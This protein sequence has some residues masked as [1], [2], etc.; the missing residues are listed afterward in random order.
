MNTPPTFADLGLSAT[1]LEALSKKGFEEPTPIQALVI[2]ELLRA[3]VDLIGQAQTGTG[4]TAAFALPLIEKLTPGVGHIQALV[5]APTRELAVQICEEISSLRG[6]KPF[7]VAPVYGGQSYTEQFRRFKMGVDILVGTP[8]RILDHLE[9]GSLKLDKLQYLI[10][11]EADE[12]LD[13]GFSED[14][15]TLLEQVNPDRCMLLFSATMPDRIR[16]IANKHMKNPKTLSVK[17]QAMTAELTEQ[18]YFEVNE[19]D[20]FESLCRIL[21]LEEDFYGI[22]FCRTK[23]QTDEIS[24]R[25][26]DRGYGA[27]AIHGDLTQGQRELVLKKFKGKRLNILCATDVAA[28]GIDVENLTHVINY[29]LPQDPE[30]YVHRIGRTGRAG[31]EGTAVTFI[32]AEEYRKMAFIE[33]VSKTRIRKERVPGVGEIIT[34]KKARLAAKVQ[35][36]LEKPVLPAIGELAKELLQDRDAA[37]VLAAVLQQYASGEFDEKTYAPI[38]DLFD[39]PKRERASYSSTA[40]FP[41]TG[42]PAFHGGDRPWDNGPGPAGK[43]RLFIAMGR[44]DGISPRKIVDLLESQGGIPSRFID[45]AVVMEEFSFVTV[46]FR[47][48]ERLIQTFRSQG[49]QGKP[50]IKLARPEDGEAGGPP[51]RPFAGPPGKFGPPKYGKPRKY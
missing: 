42:A 16:L 11:D 14:I 34:L 5:L 47:D 36:S 28:R 4:K 9:R 15:D 7:S 44:T 12:M 30:A 2:P 31:K 27:E 18:I 33:R 10:L 21:D 20:K 45:D 23:L 51:R 35:E 49:H 26:A 22:V 37:E 1:V 3:D 50:L 41:G 17:G 19:G 48:A 38:R 6:T 13:M 8:G 32:T 46:P 25:L 40:G 29:S 39:R 24:H 43:A